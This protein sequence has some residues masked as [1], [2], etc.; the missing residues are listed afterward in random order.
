MQYLSRPANPVTLRSRCGVA[1]GG[2]GHTFALEGD[3]FVV[4]G[5]RTA[6]F[7]LGPC[8]KCSICLFWPL[9]RRA[10]AI[11]PAWLS[12]YRAAHGHALAS[13]SA[14]RPFPAKQLAPRFLVTAVKG[15]LAARSE[16]S[17]AGRKRGKPSGAD[18]PRPALEA[19]KTNGLARDPKA[20]RPPAGAPKRKR[21]ETP[22]GRSPG[23]ASATKTSV[24]RKTHSE[25]VNLLNLLLTF[26]GDK[27]RG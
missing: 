2:K 6:F 10:Q 5:D 9:K 20:D 23:W 27:L 12:P 15:R 26:F 8:S 11:R 1:S 3:T 21:R 16:S 14:Q 7:A 17:S 22:R 18:A 25:I 13:P 19:K 24:T 4:Y